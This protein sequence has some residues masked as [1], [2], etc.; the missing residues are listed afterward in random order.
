MEILLDTAVGSVRSLV[1]SVVDTARQS[2][3]RFTQNVTKKV[4]LFF[5]SF[6]GVLF[7]LIGFAQLLTALYRIPGSGF[8]IIGVFVLMFV[9]GVYVVD[10][11]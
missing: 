5:L 9:A 11:Q 3:T 7:F 6:V 4:I 1:E 10:R 2:V 8:L